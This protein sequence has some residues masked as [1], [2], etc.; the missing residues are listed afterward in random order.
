MPIVHIALDGG[1]RPLQRWECVAQAAQLVEGQLCERLS[2]A[3]SRNL[4][5][6]AMAKAGSSMFA[7]HPAPST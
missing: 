6:A 3:D 7:L 4:P 5:M 2:T 1:I